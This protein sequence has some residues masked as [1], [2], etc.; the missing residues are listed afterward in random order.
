MFK[1]P[2]HV[3]AVHYDPLVVPPYKYTHVRQGVWIG[4]HCSQ[5]EY[6]KNAQPFIDEF[7][8]DW[9]KAKAVKARKPK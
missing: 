9:D 2:L 1:P 5:E 6:D 7:Y 4:E 8:R 3:G